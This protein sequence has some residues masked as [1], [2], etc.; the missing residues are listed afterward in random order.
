MTIYACYPDVT[1][2]GENLDTSAWIVQGH[3]V[4]IHGVLHVASN[5]PA[6]FHRA[7]WGRFHLTY[8][9]GVKI[10]GCNGPSGGVPAGL[11][12]LLI[13]AVVLISV[14]LFVVKRNQTF[15]G[16]HT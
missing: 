5:A 11:I 15:P 4:N 16:R 7:Y 1:Y 8:G 12:A 13:F 9:V 3:P 2:P 6:G 14:V 10:P